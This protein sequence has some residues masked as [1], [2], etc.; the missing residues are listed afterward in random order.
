MVLRVARRPRVVHLVLFGR[1][2]LVG[3]GRA[4]RGRRVVVGRRALIA[5]YGHCAVALPVANRRRVRAVDRD[6]LVVDTEAVA[7][8]VRVGEEAALVRWQGGGS[9]SDIQGRVQKLKVARST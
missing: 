3:L 6:L 4:D 7:V 1:V 8:R 2:R 9:S 5:V